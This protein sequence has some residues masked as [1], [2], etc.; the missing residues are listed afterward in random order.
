VSR[1]L[2]TPLWVAFLLA[3]AVTSCGRP[4]P[5]AGFAAPRTVHLAPDD[6]VLV[7]DQGTGRATAG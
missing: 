3:A 7:T 6:R 1:R 5:L 2:A 4:D